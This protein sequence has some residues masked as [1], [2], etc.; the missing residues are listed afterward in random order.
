V[1][2]W[3][4]TSPCCERTKTEERREERAE[5]SRMRTKKAEEAEKENQRT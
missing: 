5:I 1:K 2:S 3:L 4:S